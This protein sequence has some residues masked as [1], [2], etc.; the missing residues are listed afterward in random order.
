[1][2]TALTLKKPTKKEPRKLKN[3][4]DIIGVAIQQYF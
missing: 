4:A 1:L 3:I 2:T